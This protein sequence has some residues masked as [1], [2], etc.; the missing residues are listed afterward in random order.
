[1]PEPPSFDASR[2]VGVMSV[3]TGPRLFQGAAGAV[4]PRAVVRVTNLDTQDASVAT[5]AGA[6]GSFSIVVPVPAERNELRFEA[7]LNDVRSAPLDLSDETGF[8]PSERFPCVKVNP[9]LALTIPKAGAQLN[10]ENGCS[11]PLEISNPRTR[12]D[13]PAF[14]APA[15]EQTLA[16]AARA[17]IPFTRS[18]EATA[19]VEEILFLDLTLDGRTIRYPISLLVAE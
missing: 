15:A 17:S 13:L 18:T 12:L 9:G 8:A 11:S 16:P 19:N 5:T 3:A 7:I 1:M 14:P 10:I 4:T 6:D 2:I